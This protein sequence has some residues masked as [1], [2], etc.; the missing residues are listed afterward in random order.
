[1]SN[2]LDRVD[3]C[4]VGKCGTPLH[5]AARY[6][7]DECAKAIMRTSVK[8]CEKDSQLGLSPLHIAAKYGSIKVMEA[9][10]NH[11]TK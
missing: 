2:F 4:M 10:L 1:M 5:I 8:L 9:M 7:Y 3:F 6:D 11:G